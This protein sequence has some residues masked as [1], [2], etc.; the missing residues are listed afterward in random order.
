MLWIEDDP[1]MDA[2]YQGTTLEVA[3]GAVDIR[4][5]KPTPG[6]DPMAEPTDAVTV[7]FRIAVNRH[8]VGPYDGNGTVNPDT[9]NAEQN[10]YST[11]FTP[12]SVKRGRFTGQVLDPPKSAQINAMQIVGRV[13]QTQR[14]QN[15]FAGIKDQEATYLPSPQAQMLTLFSAFTGPQPKPEGGTQ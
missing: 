8:E 5:Q 13:G 7:P 15:L 1:V 10:G 2:T 9:V 14:L 12:S 4:T 6:A 3:P 11:G